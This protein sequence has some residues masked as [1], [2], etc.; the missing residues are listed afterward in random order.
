MS[1][2]NFEI[3]FLATVANFVE[4]IIE[5]ILT[6]INTLYKLISVFCMKKKLSIIA[7]V[8]RMNMSPNAKYKKNL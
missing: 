8:S 5:I 1:K 6:L 3:K 4:I 2:V 7:G